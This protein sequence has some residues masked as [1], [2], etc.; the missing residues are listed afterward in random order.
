[1]DDAAEAL[2]Q[3]A[4]FPQAAEGQGQIASPQIFRLLVESSGGRLAIATVAMR[5]VP[6]NALAA[7]LAQ[8]LD[9]R[10]FELASRERVCG[11]FETRHEIA[12]VLLDIDLDRDD[13]LE[14]TAVI[15]R[16]IAQAARRIRKT[17]PDAISLSALRTAV[18]NR[19]ADEWL[20]T[21]TEFISRLDPEAV[22]QARAIDG[23]RPSSYSYLT[24]I[25][26][27]QRRNRAQAMA[28]FPLLRPVLMTPQLE[29]VR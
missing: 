6:D 19:L 9:E 17:E 14:V 1:M 13:P 8:L 11:E 18:T 3:W 4:V 12:L 24:T 15:P 10:Q 26:A 20:A 7:N 5:T 23:L 29:A 25:S 28:V 21:R 22:A 27:E 2:R 16:T